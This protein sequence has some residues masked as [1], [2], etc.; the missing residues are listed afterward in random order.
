MAQEEQ[1]RFYYE[2]GSHSPHRYWSLVDHGRLIA[3]GGLTNIEWENRLAEISLIVSPRYRRK[4]WGRKAVDLIFAEGFGNMNL[5]R[6]HGIAYGC[7]PGYLFWQ[8]ITEEYK[9]ALSWQPDRKYWKGIYHGGLIFSVGV[10]GFHDA[11]E[12]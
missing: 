1:E 6:I 7:N 8:K 3:F 11:G 10:K 9:G 12:Q 5:N 4:G 2:L